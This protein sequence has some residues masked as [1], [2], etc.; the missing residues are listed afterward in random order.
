MLRFVINC[1]IFI[2]RMIIELIFCS[3]TID[4]CKEIVS[5]PFVCPNCGKSFY[6]KWYHLWF[7]RG[8]TVSL[9]NK[10][11][12]RCPHCKKWDMCKWTNKDQD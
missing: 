7:L 5:Q 1:I 2:P 11:N 8:F 9:K 12:L 4:E 3:W 6:A 10:A